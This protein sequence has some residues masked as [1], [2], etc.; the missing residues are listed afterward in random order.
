MATKFCEGA[1]SAGAEIEVIKLRHRNIRNCCGC[2][3]CWTKTPGIC[4]YR[5]DMPELLVKLRRA[6]LIVYVSPLFV[7]SVTALLKNFLDR[8]IPN[9][10]PYMLK[11]DGYTLHPYRY[12]ED[13]EDG[14]DG[15]VIFSAGGFPE[16]E[17]NFDGISNIFR[18]LSDHS[19][20]GSLMGEFYLPAAEMI[21]Q[22][23]YQQRR[24]MIEESCFEADR[25]A[26]EEGVI[27]R[28]LMERIQTPGVTQD[29][30][31]E[32]ADMFWESIEGK[33]AYY[34]ATPHL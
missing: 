19:E 3:N 9:M 34:K 20:I 1:E 24:R 28:R 6:D 31:Q 8:C 33:T 2:F 22:P 11:K 18:N 29:E 21:A 13:G 17:G 5:D 30:F 23:V 26:V 12:G 15:F 14:E 10:E 4:R 32:Q 27:D 25:Q 16:V 7:F